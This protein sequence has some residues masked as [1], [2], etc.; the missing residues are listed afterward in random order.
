MATTLTL[1]F[2]VWPWWYVVQVGDSRCYHYWDG[3]LRQV[4][5]DQTVAQD[6]VDRGALPPERVAASPFSHVLASAIGGAEASPVVTRVDIRHR[7]ACCCSAA[8]G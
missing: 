4:T 6:L 3:V 8:T 2:A 7:G 1:G 5:R